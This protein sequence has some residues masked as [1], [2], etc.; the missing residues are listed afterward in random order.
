MATEFVP[1]QVIVKDHA[2]TYKLPQAWISDCKPTDHVVVPWGKAFTI[3]VVESINEI[4]F[5]PAAKFEYKWIVQGVC[6]EAYNELVAGTF[7]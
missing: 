5:D 4:P 6:F 1:V 7:P 3:G 2:Y